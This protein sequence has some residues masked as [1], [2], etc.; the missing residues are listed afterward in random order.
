MVLLLTSA[1][2]SAVDS[3][4][5]GV[6]VGD[7]AVY[8]LD[9]LRFVVNGSDTANTN[10]ADLFGDANRTN[11]VLITDIGTNSLNYTLGLTNGTNI[12]E[13]QQ[14]LMDELAFGDQPFIFPNG[15]LPV[16]LP[17]SVTGYSNYLSYL[18][19][20]LG[21][22]NLGIEA[23]I[24]GSEDLG[25][26]N[27]ITISGLISNKFLNITV[28]LSASDVPEFVNEVLPGVNLTSGITLNT[29]ATISE[30]DI[31]LELA[32]NV[33]DG[34]LMQVDIDAGI[35][36]N[37]TTD[38]GSVETLSNFNATL[39]RD[40]YKPVEEIISDISEDL[41]SIAEE[42]GLPLFPGFVVLAPIMAIYA[43]KRKRN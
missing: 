26:I 30:A 23:L 13:S 27:D 38:S 28:G 43:L 7:V 39:V 33:T 17:L 14:I 24:G 6:E 8:Y 25:F 37:E 15:S 21:A 10:F 32:Y 19:A 4:S 18:A 22:L 40:S 35:K 34:L 11:I 36:A 16:V 41:S 3:A 5:W 2:A 31:D 12:L 42:R 9:D 29:N 20:N 1:S